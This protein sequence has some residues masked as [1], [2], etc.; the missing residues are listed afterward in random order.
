[1]PTEETGVSQNGKKSLDATPPFAE[2]SRIK[3]WWCLGSTL[4]ILGAV[5]VLAAV[6]HW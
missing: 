6:L 1:M 5:L 3:S 2:E 4:V